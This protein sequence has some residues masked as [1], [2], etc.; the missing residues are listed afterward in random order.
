MCGGL[1]RRTARRLAML[2]K[3]CAQILYYFCFFC[4]SFACIGT[5]ASFLFS[6]NTSKY[7]SGGHKYL[8]ITCPLLLVGS[9]IVMGVVRCCTKSGRNHTSERQEMTRANIRSSSRMAHWQTVFP[10][11]LPTYDETVNDSQFHPF[12]PPPKYEEV[13]GSGWKPEDRV[14]QACRGQ[15]RRRTQGEIFT[16]T[17]PESGHVSPRYSTSEA[18]LPR[19]EILS[20]G[21]TPVSEIDLAQLRNVVHENFMVQENASNSDEVA[22][23]GRSPVH[24]H[25]V[26]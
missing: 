3:D 8:K 22:V 24:E 20:C 26:A 6:R 7:D 16:I 10:E 23:Q 21:R 18:E 4:A 17:L 9:F 25:E 5:F 19:T 14:L 11:V 1:A 2:K 12:E 13:V 15:H